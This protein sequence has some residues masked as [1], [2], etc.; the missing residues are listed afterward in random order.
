METV[1]GKLSALEII[2]RTKEECRR[3]IPPS[4]FPL[5]VFK[6]ADSIDTALVRWL[7]ILVLVLRVVLGFPVTASGWRKWINKDKSQDSKR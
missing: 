7:V 1:E 6:E 4:L 2:G 3:I 5:L